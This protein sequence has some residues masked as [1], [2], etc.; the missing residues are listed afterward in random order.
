MK[1]QR[2]PRLSDVAE[3]AG[4]SQSA[5]SIVLNGR[6]GEAIRVSQE[7]QDRIWAAVRELGYGAD[8]VAR[9]LA[10]GQIDTLALIVRDISNPFFSEVALAV[11]QEAEKYSY[12]VLLYNTGVPA[13]DDMRREV[14]FLT[15][16]QKWPI[17]GLII[18][19]DTP[20][21]DK[22]LREVQQRQTPIVMISPV[23]YEDI[24]TVYIDDEKAAF[25]AVTYL[26]GRGHRRIAHISGPETLPTGAAR[27]QGYLQSLKAKR[28]PAEA[29]LVFK[30]DFT[31]K[32][33]ERCMREIL[34]S[35]DPPTAVFAA[36][37]LMAFGALRVALN[38]GVS[39]PADI[40][41]MG[42]D[43]IQTLT[44][45]ALST[46]DHAQETMG[47]TTVQLLMQRLSG[48]A[49]EG[50]QAIVIPHKLVIRDTA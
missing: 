46:V 20:F 32:G 38:A 39:V 31:I 49:P 28:L 10:K 44:I 35:D 50:H 43:N 21:E 40:A 30:S 1:K 12:N 34:A 17:A 8:P 25:D 4:V 16:A 45:P 42:F 48:E 26:I 13:G 19:Q 36:N 18:C 3:L 22:A 27:L 9:S 2:R 29:R 14:D 6:V 37:D 24:D 5:V 23:L 11:Q 15:Y 33:G 7:T 41:I 47:R